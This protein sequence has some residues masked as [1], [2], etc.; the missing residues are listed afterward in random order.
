M[1]RVRCEYVIAFAEVLECRRRAV[2]SEYLRQKWHSWSLIRRNPEFLSLDIVPLSR[3]LAIREA[4]RARGFRRDAIVPLCKPEYGYVGVHESLVEIF[5]GVELGTWAINRRT[6]NWLWDELDITRPHNILE[7]G[8]GSSTCMFC[9][10]AKERCQQS[11][12]VSIDQ[13]ANEAKRTEMRL[14]HF[15]LIGQGKVIAMPIDATDHYVVD[16]ELLANLFQGQKVDMVF[17]DGPAGRNGC[18]ENTLPDV[19]P[20]LANKGRFFLHDALRDGELAV[21]QSWEEIRGVEV[22]GIL[23]YGNG[24]A[25]GNWSFE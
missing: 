14:A 9:A 17:V 22:A 1:W 15:G 6:M 4:E 7:F 12:I 19:F 10:W 24:L 3:W 23:P 16:C 21:L 8:S 11:R 13:S 25:V 18:R 5:K 2:F 20:L